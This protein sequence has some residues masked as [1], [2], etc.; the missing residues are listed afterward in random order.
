MR[1]TRF[2]GLKII[3]AVTCITALAG[4]A[5]GPQLRS[6]DDWLR[7][8]NRGYLDVSKED[9]IRAAEEVLR[10]ADGDDFAFAHHNDGFTAQRATMHYIVIAVNFGMDSWQFR[11]TPTQEGWIH[12][13]VSVSTQGQ[14]A[15]ISQPTLSGGTPMMGPAAA[16]V[17]QFANLYE[18]FWSRVDYMLGKRPDWPSC[19]ARDVGTSAGTAQL[20][21]PMTTKDLPPSRRIVQPR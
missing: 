18:L 13:Q 8:T 16:G 17:V 9:V 19:P 7:S 12:A 5:S 21:D 14:A 3:A 20:C 15:S 10:L 6:R 4:C 2:K 11:A 1:A